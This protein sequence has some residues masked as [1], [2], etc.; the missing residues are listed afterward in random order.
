MT[1]AML[2]GIRMSAIAGLLDKPLSAPVRSRGLRLNSELRS[3]PRQA[4]S[5]DPEQ[6]IP[7][8]NDVA[9]SSA[10]R[11]NEWLIAPIPFHQPNIGW[12][13]QGAVGYL[14]HPFKDEPDS[15]PWMTGASGLYSS[16]GSWMGGI[17][18]KMNLDHDRWRASFAGLSGQFNYDFFGIGTDAGNV[19]ASVPLNQEMR[20]ATAQIL[21]NVGGKWYLGPGYAFLHARINVDNPS[22]LPPSLELPATELDSDLA[23]LSVNLQHDSRDNEFYPL[24]GGYSKLSVS[25]VE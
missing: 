24:K 25:G 4:Y 10:P 13:V 2:M 21:R 18:H 3:D 16:N 11:K 20:L 9:A 5:V 14:Y 8:D 23:F 1:A 17:F 12:G 7:R 19:G 15:R 22:S 6:N